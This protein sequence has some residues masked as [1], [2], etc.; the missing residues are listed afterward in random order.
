M[1]F[2][3]HAW[4]HDPWADEVLCL[5]TLRKELL[6]SEWGAGKRNVP[7]LAQDRL[8]RG[9]GAFLGVLLVACTQHEQVQAHPLDVESS[10]HSQQWARGCGDIVKVEVREFRRLTLLDVEVEKFVPTNSIARFCR[11]RTEDPFFGLLDS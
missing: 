5:L 6:E 1:P 4:E 9:E 2:P 8:S 3:T 7:T 10:E 11:S